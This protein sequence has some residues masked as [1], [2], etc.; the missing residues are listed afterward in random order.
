MDGLK[1]QVLGY[2][3]FNRKSD[4]KRMTIL[5]AI[6][7]CTLLLWN[8][9]VR[10]LFRNIRLVALASLSCPVLLSGRGSKEVRYGRNG[11]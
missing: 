6:S 8:A 5:T 10:N 9:S 2:R 1:F 3:D 7:Q 4:N 11:K